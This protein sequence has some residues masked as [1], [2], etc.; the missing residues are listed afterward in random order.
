MLGSLSM[1]LT[2][3]VSSPV[4]RGLFVHRFNRCSLQDSSVLAS[5]LLQEVV[6]GKGGQGI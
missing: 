6:G 1:A 5:V 4:G 2:M 3:R